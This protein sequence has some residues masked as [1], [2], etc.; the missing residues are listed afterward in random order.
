MRILGIADGMTGGAALL[1]GGKITYAVHEER[2]TRAKMATGFPRES[3]SRVLKDTH[4]SPE[5]IDA[6][7]VATVSEFFREQAVAYDGWLLREQAPLK[8]LLL[9]TSSGAAALFGGRPFLKRGYYGLKTVLGRARRKAIQ[10]ILRR[11]W[12]FSCPIKFIDHHYAHACS[13]YFTSGLRDATII[14]MD[15]AGDNVCSRVYSARDGVFQQLCSVDSFDSIGNYYAYI[16]HLC[17]FKA[18]KHEGKITGL[19]A[20]GKPSYTD[21][22]RRFI[23]YQDGKTVNQGQV[24][25]WSAVKAL[26]RALPQPFKHEDLASSIQHV[27]EEAGC[28][29]AQ[30]YVERTG[31]GDL[32]LAGGV[33]ANVKFNERLH[34]L[35]NVRSVFIHPG[36]GDEG[37]AVGAAFALGATLGSRSNSEIRPSKL[38][39][40]YLGPGYTDAEIARAIEVQG[41]P[42]ESVQDIGRKIAE[43]LAQGKV[44]ARFD[45]RME[46]GPRALGNR[47]ILYQ[48]TDTSVND[49]LNHRLQRTE[50][51]PF[52]PVTL[53]EYAGQAYEN[54]EGASYTAEF[55][56]ITFECTN[57]M[58]ENCPAVVHVDGTARPQIIDKNAN[59]TYYAIVDEYR[60]ITGL[61][62]VINTSFNMHE[63]PMV[64]S[65]SDA[66]RAF[67][68]ADLDWLAMGN[69]LIRHPKAQD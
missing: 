15:G 55:M 60:K 16:T 2:L 66:I 22:L 23:C 30:H 63:E 51:M 25:Y 59:R 10:A 19:A 11:D 32:A 54:L 13:A 61:P 53:K 49:W 1:E 58:K 7:A 34:E 47:S 6:I 31:I 48:P 28:A 40:V 42:A 33:F 56:T 44:V 45:G 4:T 39:D 67:L 3:I 65:P 43:L 37:L 12:G 52:A 41:L 9:S 24:Y 8:E 26:Q 68:E 69:F 20:Y 57:W 14:T 21:I 46:Y 64:C 5:E 62:S 38:D 36:M 17:G 35:D 18:Q 29:Y 50:F 27:L